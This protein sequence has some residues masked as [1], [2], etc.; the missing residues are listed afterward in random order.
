MCPSKEIEKPSGLRVELAPKVLIDLCLLSMFYIR[1]QSFVGFL[2]VN[3]P[4]SQVLISWSWKIAILEC[5]D[6]NGEM[7]FKE[8]MSGGYHSYCYLQRLKLYMVIFVWWIESEI[9]KIDY[10]EVSDWN[11][12]GLTQWNVFS[13]CL[14]DAG[15]RRPLFNGAEK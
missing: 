13:G 9:S 12:I 1:D 6:K 14:K 7:H 4:Q 3:G 11:V 8:R 5:K 15:R 10:C 2:D